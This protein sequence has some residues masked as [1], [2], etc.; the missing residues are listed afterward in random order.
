ML[1]Q[2]VKNNKYTVLKDLEATLT[3]TEELQTIPQLMYDNN[4]DQDKAKSMFFDELIEHADQGDNFKR[5]SGCYNNA[6]FAVGTGI[7]YFTIEITA[8]NL[9]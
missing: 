6:D 5:L 3:E 8:E 7:E 9:E 2:Y 4:I 1:I